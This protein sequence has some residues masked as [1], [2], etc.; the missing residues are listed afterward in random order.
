MGKHRDPSKGR[1]KSYFIGFNLHPDLYCR[2]EMAC[3]KTGLNL[4]EI[5]RRALVAWLDNLRDS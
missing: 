5:V 4:S 1:R 3:Q 2:V